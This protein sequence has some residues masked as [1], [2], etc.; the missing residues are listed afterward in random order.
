MKEKL[1]QL[2]PGRII[3]PI[4]LN[5]ISKNNYLV[6]ILTYN[7]IPIVLGHGKRNRAKV[8]FDNREQ[9]TTSHIKAL[10]V[11]LYTLFGNGVFERYIIDCNSKDEAKIIENL[12]HKEIGGN[13]RIIPTEIRQK[14]FD[15]IDQNS[16]TYLV[17]EIALRSSFDGLSDIR[18]WRADNILSNEVWCQISEKLEL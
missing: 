15:G 13:N 8:I 1:N 3:S 5:E 17:L 12:L 6:Y 16:V 14:L 18:K 9:I 11:R 2:Y 4:D 10:F 7:D